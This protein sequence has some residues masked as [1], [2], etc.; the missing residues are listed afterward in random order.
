MNDRAPGRNE[1]SRNNSVDEELA[2]SC[3]LEAT[4]PFQPR[5]KMVLI[6]GSLLAAISAVQLWAMVVAQSFGENPNGVCQPTWTAL[7]TGIDGQVFS[8]TVFDPDGPGPAPPVLVVGGTFTSAGGMPANNIAIWD[9]SAWH[10]LGTG[11]D[12]TVWALAA[13]DEDGPGPNPP[14]LFAGGY[15]ITAGGVVVNNIA[16]WDG[17][18]WS[19]VEGGA[20]GK[21][22]GVLALTVFDE[23]G[24]GQ[25]ALFAGGEFT[26]M[27]GI[28]TGHVARWNGTTWSAVGDVG[29]PDPFDF[30]SALANHD[31]DGPGPDPPSLFVG[32]IFSNIGG[33]SASNIARWNGTSWSDVG[34]GTNG[35]VDDLVA[36][37]E[38]G[39]G[40]GLPALFATGSF[41]QAGGVIV[42]GIGRWNG[43]S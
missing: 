2:G 1:P 29:T 32:G 33:I 31:E 20:G 38:D 39:P 19:S 36:F 41:S 11:V 40:P 35:F 28:S 13:F 3:S 15:F 21:L 9:G 24:G 14:V 42:N 7:G 26:S 43:T 6:S 10:P 12:D 5:K 8:S 27:G 16:R 4:E 17:A 30:V 22:R 34:G 25:P 18:N 37:D 23:N